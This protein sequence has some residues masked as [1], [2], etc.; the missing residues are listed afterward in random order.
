[1][2][3]FDHARF[4]AQFPLIGKAP[5]NPNLVY[6]D[7]GATTQKPS[8][9]IEAEGAF[10]SSAN[11]NVHRA[12]F[13]LAA[14]ATDLFEGC[15]T[16]LA[17][18]FNA[19][20]VNEI[21]FTKGTTE[22]INLVA[23]SW[24]Q[25]Y[26]SKGDEIILSAAEHHANIVPWQLIAEKTGAKIKWAELLPSGRIDLEQF[27]HLLTNKTKMVAINHISNV[28]GVIN[29][30]REIVKLAK[31]VGAY[32]LIDGAQSAA[33]IDVDVQSLGVDFYV[34]SSHKMYGPTGVGVL[35]GRR[36][37][38]DSMPPY[39]TGGEMI[40]KVT[41]ERTTFNKLPFKF[42]AGT[43]NIAGVVAFSKALDFIEQFSL[44]GLS[45]KN[46]LIDYAYRKLSEVPQ[47]SFLAEGKPDIPVFSFTLPQHLQDISAVLD[48]KGIAVRAGSLCA[49]PLMQSKGIEGCIRVSL[50]P[51]NTF[52]EI[53][54]LI[55]SLKRVLASD[56]EK[57]PSEAQQDDICADEAIM[58]DKFKSAGSWD[59]KQR[60]IMLLGKSF[61]RM[62]REN[63]IDEFLVQGCESKAWVTV[64]ESNGHYFFEGD[65]DARIIR[66]LLAIVFAAFQGK[67][68]QEILAF[69]IKEYFDSLG[70]IK[71]L[72]PSRGNGL[73]AIVAYISEQLTS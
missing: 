39:Q 60:E 36:E 23:L 47:L 15:R 64:S 50:A 24:G 32:V 52:E 10:Y 67:T 46:E 62:A 53:D 17:N 18:Y 56:D 33:A 63:R 9:V 73:N 19:E 12:S 34:C 51:Y 11:S 55:E 22:S 68:Q 38:L 6:F 65:S 43:P 37:I 41:R 58:R 70:L 30:V 31:Q 13:S 69:D 54:Y 1:M 35:Y 66:G 42:E 29:P 25:T 14:T 49:M 44:K 28:L 16:K 48:S 40:T 71:H 4:R 7:N 45:F 26:L 27:E 61:T 5:L 20:H 72:S 21:I 59:L 8:A 57:A 2:S 3:K